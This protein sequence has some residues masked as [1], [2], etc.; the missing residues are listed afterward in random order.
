VAR[1]P[2]ALLAALAALLLAAP[3]GANRAEHKPVA[4]RPVM[5]YVPPPAGSY[6]LQV[7]QQAPDGQV[8]GRDGLQH[9][10]SDYT[11]GRIT[12]LGDA[13]HP[14]YPRGSNGAGQ[15]I[16][17]ARTLT[18]CFKNNKNMEDALKMYEQTRL[19]AANDL[20]LMNR[21]NPPDAILRE[22]WQRSGDKPFARIEDVMTEAEMR[23]LAEN[24]QRI[25]GFERE[26]LE[27]RASLA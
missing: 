17:D 8:V 23:E 22:V 15:A 2:S 10:L 11:R 1:R 3:A 13:A 18:G 5:D 24:Y 20:V 16:L 9:R 14:M 12:L 25:A 27:R 7:I 26:A 21:A 6:T 19:K 4:A